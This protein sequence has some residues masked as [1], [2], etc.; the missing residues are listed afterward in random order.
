MNGLT[1][2]ALRVGKPADRLIQASELRPG[3]M[4]CDRCSIR[5]PIERRP[6]VFIGRLERSSLIGE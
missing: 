6:V 4:I 1:D 5:A 3:R 2:Q